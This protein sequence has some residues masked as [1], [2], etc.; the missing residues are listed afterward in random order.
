MYKQCCPNDVNPSLERT[1]PRVQPTAPEYRNITR[2]N[3]WSI[4][5]GVHDHAPRAPY[6]RPTPPYPPS[7][8]CPADPSCGNAAGPESHGPLC[9]LYRP[10]YSNSA[11]DQI[12]ACSGSTSAAADRNCYEL[13]GATITEPCDT[14]GFKNVQAQRQWHGRRSFTDPFWHAPTSIYVPSDYIDLNPCDSERMSAEQIKYLTVNV[15]GV[16]AWSGT[17][18]CAGSGGGSGSKQVS[19]DANSGNKTASGSFYDTF[20]AESAHGLPA[21][22]FLDWLQNQTLAIMFNVFVARLDIMFADQ[23]AAT[24]GTTEITYAAGVWTWKDISGGVHDGQLY[25]TIGID[26][27]GT[28]SEYDYTYTCGSYEDDFASAFSLGR[29]LTVSVTA[30]TITWSYS[31]HKCCDTRATGFSGDDTFTGTVT[32]SNTNTFASVYAD[33]QG[34]LAEWDL[35]NDVQYPWRQ[36]GFLSVAP[37]VSRAEPQGNIVPNT[38][39]F[40]LIADSMARTPGDAGYVTT[41]DVDPNIA[42]GYDGSIRGKPSGFPGGPTF[43]WDHLTYDFCDS[44]LYMRLAGSFNRVVPYALGNEVPAEQTDDVVPCEATA[45]TNNLE[46]CQLLPGKWVTNFGDGV[47]IQDWRELAVQRKRRKVARPCG[48]DAYL[49]DETTVR[50][51]IDDASG[52]FLGSLTFPTESMYPGSVGDSIIYLGPGGALFTVTAV[53]STDVTATYTGPLPVGYTSSHV[54]PLIG[55]RRFASAGACDPTLCDTTPHGRYLVVTWSFNYRDVAERARLIALAVVNFPAGGA[56]IR[57]AQ[58]ANGLSSAV[59]GI[60]ITQNTECNFTRPNCFRVLSA[61]AFPGSIAFDEE[62]S[63]V[64]WQSCVQQFME[65]PFN[66]TPHVNCLA[67]VDNLDGLAPYDNKE[68]G[69]D[70]LWCHTSPEFVTVGETV[71]VRYWYPQ[72]SWVEAEATEFYTFAEMQGTLATYN[73]IHNRPIPPTTPSANLASP[74]ETLTPWRIFLGECGCITGGGNFAA[75]YIKEVP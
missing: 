29:S 52:D 55:K 4:T 67:V 58:A 68:D 72:R 14:V 1:G 48:D 60:I 10:A 57:S 12:Q 54:G 9:S 2:V 73:R 61:A 13:T 59:T 34:L 36:D 43:S 3:D 27:S 66:Q 15:T 33:A 7:A 63:G 41:F 30:T 75:D 71:I 42:A 24:P 56:A 35:T 8:I 16:W 26:V 40:P 46:A 19:V 31:N 17:G 50:C 38:I 6:N 65:E 32:L 74:L 39:D 47:R 53:T 25:R 45:W 28:F 20:T 44:S 21:W 23:A 5:A 18:A 64:F 62:Y 69:S 49:I 11:P 37:I 70:G 22:D 51:L